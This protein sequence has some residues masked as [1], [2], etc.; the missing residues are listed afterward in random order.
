MAVACNRDDLV[1]LQKIHFRSDT[2]ALANARIFLKEVRNPYLFKV[3][4]IIVHV[5]FCDS[6]QRTLQQCI[7]NLLSRNI[8]YEN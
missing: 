4:D 7:E 1:D 3:D 5:E 2:N 8:V 6:S